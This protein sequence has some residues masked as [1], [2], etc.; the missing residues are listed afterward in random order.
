MDMKEQA[1][2]NSD[3]AHQ[4]AAT[5]SG[6]KA[7]QRTGI[8]VFPLRV[9]V[10]PG[11]LMRTD[12]HPS[13]PEQTVTLASR[14]F[15]YSLRTLRMGYLYVLLDKSVWQAYEVTAEGCLRQF[16]AHEMPEGMTVNPLA[17]ACRT[18]GHDIIASFINL[19]DNLYSEAWLA[20]SSDPWTQTVLDDYQNS[21]RPDSRFTKISLSDLKNAPANL[22]GAL[23]IDPSLTSLKENVAEFSTVF[24]PDVIRIGEKVSGSVH[25]FYP[26]RDA[27]KQRQ[28][29][30][31]IA[32]MGMRYDC[33]IVALPLNDSVGVVQELNNSRMQI[34]E[35][36]QAYIEQPGV[37]HRHMIS[38][39]I[40]DYLRKLKTGIAENAHPEFDLDPSMY[41]LAGPSFGKAPR[42]ISKDDVAEASFSEQRA[43]LM[44][45]YD[46][47]ARAKFAQEFEDYFS[48]PQRLLTAID[49]DLAAWYRSEEWLSLIHHDYSPE[50][51]VNSWVAQTCTLAA[52]VQGGAMGA[53]TDKVWQEEWLTKGTSPA[54]LGFT[55]M[56]PSQLDSVFN[57]GNYKTILTSDDF[58][59]ALKSPI[60]QRSLSSRMLAASG[61]VGRLGDKLDESARK[62]FMWMTQAAML[63]AG[64]PVVLLRYR[65]TVGELQA[66]LQHSPALALSVASH[67]D[68]FGGTGHQGSSAA[69]ITAIM[70]AQ[71]KMRDRVVDVEFSA[72]GTVAGLR[73]MTPA[74]GVTQKVASN[75]RL[76]SAYHDVFI[77]GLSLAEKGTGEAVLRTTPEGLRYYRELGRRMVSGDSAGLILGA[78]LMGLQ[79]YHWQELSARLKASV[80]NDV[81]MTAD[82]AISTLLLIEGFSEVMGFA[83]KLSIKQ[84]WL[85]LS[86][87]EQV[88]VPVRFGA[89]LGGIAGVVDGIRNGVHAS[90][91]FGAGDK[92]AGDYYVASAFT[93]VAGGV[94]SVIYGAQGAFALTAITEAG[95]MLTPFGFAFLMLIAGA[96]L[97]A[98]ASALRST[99]LEIWLRRTCFG[100]PARRHP[101]D[102]VWHAESMNDL[103]EAMVDY[104][105]IVSGMVA[106]VAFGG[107]TTLQTVPYSR[108]EFRVALPGWDAAK[109]GWSVKVTR[110]GD[111]GV[112][113]SESQGAPGRDDHQQSMRASD[114]YAGTHELTVEQGTLVMNG[115]VWAEQSRTPGVTMVA[116]YWVDSAKPDTQMSLT[117]RAE[118]SWVN[119]D[120][121]QQWSIK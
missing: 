52:C 15:K 5:P 18:A 33:R 117:V 20:F 54:Y 36:T 39:A 106:D 101:G 111:S 80:G 89:V 105:A 79:M 95:I 68:V 71:G 116:D 104:R 7:C 14:E 50:T 17:E 37:F 114:Y 38:E 113:F 83:Y 29:G 75:P 47:P 6:C 22:P 31:K 27:D 49:N 58:A 100:I 56:D 85:I 87:S 28:M 120:T 3:A 48:T 13:V 121:T 99:P 64:E 108:V 35:Y 8:P 96:M 112:L 16:N 45:N 84:N 76:L 26:R 61:S 41:V 30:M 42:M 97:A 73:K 10:V 21:L 119:S 69:R 82:T 19:D 11:S 4:A 88:P 23:V 115:T 77:S 34:A 86:A 32:E 78:G 60:V 62:G 59:N 44:T 70:A 63:S 1:Q 90:E 102:I 66:Q 103:A 92:N 81:D 107:T 24:F 67:S 91:S 51:S 43:R 2:R 93:S 65:T 72:P 57:F 110:D 55:G 46:E 118:P 9:A 53:A 25:G 94:I 40:T 98:K 109:G 12:W 74:A